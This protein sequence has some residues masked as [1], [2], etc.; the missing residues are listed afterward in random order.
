MRGEYGG[1]GR[2][3]V[4]E[5]R[6]GRMTDEVGEMRDLAWRGGDFGRV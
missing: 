2:E 4:G 5:E 1:M 3:E 6:M